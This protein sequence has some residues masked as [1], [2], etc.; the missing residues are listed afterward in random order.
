MTRKA[1]FLDLG[2]TLVTE[3]TSRASVYASVARAH[4]LVVEDAELAAAMRRVHDE[5]PQRLPGGAF[6][7]SDAW[8]RAFQERVF[9]GHGLGPERF[10]ALSRALFAA[11]EEARTFRLHAG[12]RE[13]V[14][15]LRHHGF[16]V[17]LI[18][19]WS[20]RLPRLLAELGLAEVLD[21]VL[22]SAELELEKPA[23][24]LFRL[25]LARAGVAPEDAL[26]AGDRLDLDVAGAQAVGMGAVL[27]DHA[28]RHDPARVACPVVRSL[29]EL[30]DRIL[31][32][33]A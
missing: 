9:A 33:P 23:P 16:V 30:R 26:H 14:L 13:L 12:A 6:R 1:V 11:F 31:S 22:G 18:S 10:A 20:A 25:A 27:V 17:G 32:G 8:F 28:R 21:P 15:D 7:Y 19:N 5:L 2:D 24:A 29:P 3:R 4:G